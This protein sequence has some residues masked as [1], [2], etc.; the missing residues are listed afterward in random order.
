MEQCGRT[1]V[2][3]LCRLYLWLEIEVKKARTFNGQDVLRS[4]RLKVRTFKGQDV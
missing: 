2:S 1:P 4:G 3:L